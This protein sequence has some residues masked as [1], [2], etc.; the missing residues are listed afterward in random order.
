VALV[1]FKLLALLANIFAL[2]IALALMRMEAIFSPLASLA[3]LAFFAVFKVLIRDFFWMDIASSTRLNCCL[4][5][6][7]MHQCK[8]RAKQKEVFG[9]VPGQRHTENQ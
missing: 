7:A 2:P 6:D 1:L 5:K 4:L 9:L 3:T 8:L